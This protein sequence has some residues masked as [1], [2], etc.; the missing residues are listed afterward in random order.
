MGIENSVFSLVIN[1]IN[2]MNSVETTQLFIIINYYIVR[3]YKER[4][5]YTSI[6]TSHTT[7]SIAVYE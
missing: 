1:N 3:R 5:S 7:C 2:N 4:V 6:P